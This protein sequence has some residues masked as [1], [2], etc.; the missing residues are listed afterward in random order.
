MKAASVCSVDETPEGRLAPLLHRFGVGGDGNA[1]PM[2]TDRR[3]NRALR[4][5]RG[6]AATRGQH[7]LSLIHR[8][9]AGGFA[10]G[11]T[12][13][14]SSGAEPVAPANSAPEAT[15]GGCGTR[16]QLRVPK[17]RMKTSALVS[18]GTCRER[19]RVPGRWRALRGCFGERERV[20]WRGSMF[21]MRDSQGDGCGSRV[22]LH[23][24]DRRVVALSRGTERTARAVGCDVVVDEVALDQPRAPWA[25]A[26]RP[27]VVTAERASSDG[28]VERFRARRHGV[29]ESFTR[30]A[31]SR[32][33]DGFAGW[34]RGSI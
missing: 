23:E 26:G 19:H 25:G 27:A 30:A 11:R 7:R 34:M 5:T 24:E 3:R 31:C 9:T 17:N 15:R 28:L 1:R 32:A 12:L 33:A 22:T 13:A 6:R 4:R 20:G 21:G 29:R 16:V 18:V 2:D 10:S 14:G 8:C